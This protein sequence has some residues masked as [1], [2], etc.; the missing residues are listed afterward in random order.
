L[1][2]LFDNN[3]SFKL[4]QL[5]D[6]VF[7]N[8]VH[9]VDIE[10]QNMPDIDIWQ[11]AK[12][13]KLTIV[14][15]DKDFYHLSSTFGSPPKLIWIL[16]GNCKIEDTIKILERNQKEIHSFIKGNKDLLILGK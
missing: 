7:P 12:K 13:G 14:T 15:K 5:L 6:H 3:L 4:P 16:L 8:S 1:S 11:F 2:L 9:V 10:M